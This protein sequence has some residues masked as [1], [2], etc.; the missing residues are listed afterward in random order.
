MTPATKG[1]ELKP[2]KRYIADVRRGDSNL[3]TVVRRSAASTKATLRKR[4]LRRS[5]SRKKADSWN[6]KL[7][8]PLY[9]LLQK[10]PAFQKT[11]ES[12]KKY[13]S[14]LRLGPVAVSHAPKTPTFIPRPHQTLEFLFPPYYDSWT[15]KAS[16]SPGSQDAAADP[17][18]GTLS[19]GVS[20]GGGSA[21][22]GAALVIA[23]QPSFFMNPAVRISPLVQYS[24]NW[25]DFSFN[26]YTAHNDGYL[27]LSV[28]STDL[29]GGD[30]RQEQQRELQLWTDGTGWTESHGS[31][32]DG[33][34]VSGTL[35][36]ADST[37][38]ATAS[39]QRRYLITISCETS[40]DESSGFWGGS[41]AIAKLA[42]RVPFVVAEQW[43]S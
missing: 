33:T 28:E 12:G 10:G 43:E 11:V 4:F 34:Q 14:G 32:G 6:E 21:D 31:N 36:P 17:A 41:L 1:R 19:V 23:F 9:E 42:V 13:L 18:D 37:F 15:W 38:F 3:R 16:G 30:L 7:Q 20:G 8:L 26:G 25:L 2:M 29:R 35:F 24:Y 39:D 27:R 40:C 5:A 22:A